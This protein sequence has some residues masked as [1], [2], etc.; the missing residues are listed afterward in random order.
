MAALA[1]I[2]TPGIATSIGERSS[3]ACLAVGHTLQKILLEIRRYR[4]SSC[5]LTDSLF[6]LGNVKR[7]RG[8]IDASQGHLHRLG[9]KAKPFLVD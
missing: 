5:T 2:D 3:N 4:S 9:A 8:K 1:K 6:E 7:S